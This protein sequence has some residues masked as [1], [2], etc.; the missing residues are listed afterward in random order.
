MLMTTGNG[1]EGYHVEKYLGI[2]SK[3]II[4]RSGLRSSL[5][6][7]IEDF[8]RTFNFRDVELTGSTELIVKAKNYLMEQFEREANMKRANAVLGVDIETSFGTDVA[9]VAVSGTAVFV[10]KDDP[11]SVDDESDGVISVSVHATNIFN[12]MLITNIELSGGYLTN[13]V[14]VEVKQTEKGELGDIKVDLLMRNRFDDEILIENVC[15]IGLQ[16]KSNKRFISTTT[17]IS[18]PNHISRCIKSCD[19]VVKKYFFNGELCIP[20]TFDMKEQTAINE[21]IAKGP[22]V[23]VIF[24]HLSQLNK[25]QE[26][27]QS[28]DAMDL[29]HESE[30]YITLAKTLGARYQFERMFGSEKKV[31]LNALRKAID[32]LE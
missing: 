24:E 1:F 10:V 6:A 14:A 19:V 22:D 28:L 15:F 26:M 7:A 12:P 8:V 13:T 18:I 11:T 27:I 25:A 2:I 30:P 31:T 3:E 23:E 5:G 4:F 20:D 32:G 17:P 21:E 29:D 16:Q 9:R